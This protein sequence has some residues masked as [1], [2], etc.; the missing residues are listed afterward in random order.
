MQLV[1]DA[2]TSWEAEGES[3]QHA[4]IGVVLMPAAGSRLYYVKHERERRAH[5]RLQGSKHTCIWDSLGLR[6]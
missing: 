1:K 6:A 4:R 3:P 5:A 2:Y